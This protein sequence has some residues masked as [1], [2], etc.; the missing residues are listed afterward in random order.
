MTTDEQ[1][2]ILRENLQSAIDTCDNEEF[3]AEERLEL[4]YDMLKPDKW[5]CMDRQAAN[6]D[7]EATLPGPCDYI[8]ANPEN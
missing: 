7:P 3:S 8:A 2:N 1:L 4:V 6:Y 5:G